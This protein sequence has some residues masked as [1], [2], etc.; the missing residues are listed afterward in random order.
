MS[1]KHLA[2]PGNV[3]ALADSVVDQFRSLGPS[4]NHRRE[5]EPKQ[6]GAETHPQEVESIVSVDHQSLPSCQSERL[7]EAMDRS[8]ASVDHQSQPLRRSE[9]QRKAPDRLTFV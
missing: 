4:G 1:I 9:R 8:T 6:T 5:G 7:R 2:P 3:E